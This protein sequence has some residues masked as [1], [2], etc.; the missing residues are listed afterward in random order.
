MECLFYIQ[1]ENLKI[2]CNLKDSMKQNKQESSMNIRFCKPFNYHG[3]DN[4][5]MVC[6][7]KKPIEMAGK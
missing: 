4:S 2:N 1:T 3:H 5:T 7:E 6:N